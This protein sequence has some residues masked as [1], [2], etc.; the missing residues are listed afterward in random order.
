MNN[1][2]IVTFIPGKRTIKITKLTFIFILIFASH[3]F[4]TR[5]VQ[6]KI[7]V[8][9]RNETLDN[10]IKDI[11]RQSEF[12][13]FVNLSE[14]DKNSRITIDKK[15]CSIEEVLSTICNGRNISYIVKNKHIILKKNTIPIKSE[16]SQIAQTSANQNKRRITGVVLD[17][18][19][20]TIIGATVIEA[21]TANG[22]ISDADGRFTINVDENSVLQISFIGYLKQEVRIKNQ[23][24]IT[25]ILKEASEALE[26]VVVVGYGQQK[27][28][29]IVGAISQAKGEDLQR[30]GGI[31]NL[32]QALTGMLP[33]VTTIQTTS[34]PGADD[35][36]I[37]IRAQSTW[38][39]SQPL[40]LVDGV[41]RR[42][43]DIDMSEVES[44]SVLKDASATAVFGVKG[45]E[46]VI[47]IKTKRGAE[48][49]TS[50]SFSA[51]F[52]VKMLTEL[53]DK[54][55]SYDS[56]TY[57][58]RGIEREVAAYEDSWVN[59]MPEKLI[60][61]Y[62]NPQGSGDKYTYP[63]VD[64][65]DEMTKK[66]ALAQRY[67]VNVSGGGKFAKYF[68]A[69]SYT[70]EGDILRTGLDVGLP[71]KTAYSYER[72]N[73]RTNLDFNLTSSTLFSVNLAGY[74]STRNSSNG[75][76][77]SFWKDVYHMAP[78]DFPAQHE[79]GTFGYTELNPGIL[80]PL[81]SLN[82]K[83]MV[84][85]NVS[86]L[87]TDFTLRQELDFITQGL[88]VQGKFS[89]DASAYSQKKVS[90]AGLISK[91]IDPVTGDV[92][93]NPSKG[94]NEY[95]YILS[96]PTLTPETYTDDKK[97]DRRVFYQ[98]QINYARKF[99]MHDVGAMALMSREQYASKEE[100]PHYREDWVGRLTYSFDDRYL[101]EFNGA[102]NGSERF[103]SRYRFG[104]FP[105]V[106]L[107][108]IISNE[109]FFKFPWLD[110]FK[111]RYSIGEVGNDSFDSPRWSYNTQWERQWT[112]PS[113]GVNR[114]E[115]PYPE[116]IERVVGNPDLQW[117]RARKQNFGIEVSILNGLL[118]ANL[119]IFKDNRDKIFLNASQRSVMD[120]FGAKPV[121]ANIGKTTAKGFEL[122]LRHQHM[123]S[124]GMMYYITGSLTHSKDKILYNES[125]VLLPSY[126]KSENFQIGQ[127]KDHISTGF[128]G[129]WD[130]VYASVPGEANNNYRLPGD[131]G[132][133][134]FNADGIIN[135][136]DK[137]PFGYPTRPQNTYNLTA[138]LEWKN[139][140]FLVQFYGV[141]NVTLQ[142]SFITTTNTSTSPTV[143]EYVGN[144]WTLDNPNANWTA[145][146]ASS[147][148]SIA[149]LNYFDGS[150]IKLKNIE[151]SYALQNEWLKKV[152]LNSVKF[153]LGGNNL[154]WWSKM[155]E[156]REKTTSNWE[157]NSYPSTRRFTLGLNVN[158]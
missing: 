54:L 108:W 56:Y 130:D 124:F 34:M 91:Y 132:I 147:V 154:L 28:A 48:G 23:K 133:I 74:L 49:Q 115:S 116:H 139:F 131:I 16:R 30:T 87:N 156:D 118:S 158:F 148:A 36:Q 155:P 42:M 72:Y 138:G 123:T 11:E 137:A 119:D 60:V 76:Y 24:E 64:W 83:G 7:S 41:E 50:L 65:A 81:K 71:Y 68:G 2:P 128:L 3:A 53:P 117:E 1:I 111:L 69:L 27:K 151:L 129:S 25:V 146:R 84:T 45:A 113:F 89:F 51:N 14:V 157:G 6:T 46:G 103:S 150:Y 58:N 102:Y 32:G 37:I 95:D 47:L 144:Y 112:P 39:N 125:P 78:G 86:Q 20:E 145:P 105:S 93:Y 19:G 62:K 33:G 92:Y 110:K 63:D 70:N 82:D 31:T 107:G 61:R 126:R 77:E 55:N 99:G 90:G 80:N 135:D 13:F 73:Y 5:N 22:V 120:Y 52:G 96:I 88:S 79:D 109:T 153:I 94:S 67:N 140:G 26:E 10:I 98:F 127:T 43:N 101:A 38:N 114:Q 8:S 35:P 4:A 121:A 152:K 40:I 75:N 141:N 134:D 97:L 100:F 122:E 143:Y 9:S 29:S 17:E 136:Y 149:N 44:V 18:R 106:A 142:Y 66:A 85:T 15:D 59:Y 12:L 57:R 104:F 21:G